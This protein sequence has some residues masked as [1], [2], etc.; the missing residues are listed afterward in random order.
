MKKIVLTFILCCIV[1][2]VGMGQISTLVGTVEANGEPLAFATVGVENTT[3]GTT[4]DEAGHFELAVGGGQQVLVISAIGYKTFR[5]DL[6]VDSSEVIHLGVILLQ[7][8]VLGL[9]EV[10]VTGTMKETFI[11][12]SPIKVDI[13][14]AKYFEKR[15]APTNL[16]EAVTLVNG[17]Q[18]VVA[19]GVCFTNS[20]S[21]NGLPGPYTAVLMDGTPMY[22]NLASVY[23][24]KCIDHDY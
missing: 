6:K 18:E 16:M 22:G 10:V 24:H 17:V 2:G 20:I 14:T 1:A 8:D 23:G 11:A 21:I 12:T 9:E 3:K 5:Q 4:T 13:I 19:C 7:E 15:T